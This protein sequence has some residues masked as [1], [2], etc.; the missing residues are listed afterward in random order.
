MRRSCHARSCRRLWQGQQRHPARWAERLL[1]K[2]DAGEKFAGVLSVSRFTPGGW[3]TEML[4]I[5]MG[6]ETVVDY[7]LRFKA[8]IRPGHLGLR[9]R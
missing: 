5:G 7:A 9:L 8:R 3:A 2:L 6:A 1:K 4:S